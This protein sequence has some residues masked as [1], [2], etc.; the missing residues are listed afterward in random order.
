MKIRL[1]FLGKQCIIINEMR[2]FP[3]GTQNDPLRNWFFLRGSDHYFE[4]WLTFRR[5][6][7][8]FFSSVQPFAYVV[9]NHTCHYGQNKR[10]DF[11]MD[12][13]PFG[14]SSQ[15]HYTITCI[16]CQLLACVQKNIIICKLALE[17]ISAVWYNKQKTAKKGS[18]KWNCCTKLKAPC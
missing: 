2:L 9:C 18:V 3:N 17:N 5:V 10:E 16:I 14:A 11:Q 12:T 15:N 1:T 4:R 8:L 13:P 7:A 6:T